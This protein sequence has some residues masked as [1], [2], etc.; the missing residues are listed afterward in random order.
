VRIAGW[1]YSYDKLPIEESIGHMARVGFDGIELATGEAFS[2]PIETLDDARV[3]RIGGLLD[4]HRLAPVAVSA[5]WRLAP[6]SEAEWEREWPKWRR[7][8]EVA[9]RLGAPFVA[10]GSGSAPEGWSREQ[11]WDALLRNGRRVADYAA[12][13]GVVVA[14][15]AHW[16][17]AVERPGDALELLAA[18]GSPSLRVNIDVCHPFALGYEL[19]SIAAILA[20]H[21]V[22]AHVC[23]VRGRHPGGPPPAGHQLVNPGEGEI[24]WPRWLGLLH[25]HG[26]Y[27]WIA[28][29]VSVMR[30][31]WPGYDPKA[32]MEEI[33]RVLTGAMAQAGV[34]R[35]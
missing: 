33:Y 24:D 16:G 25:Q 32:C 15:E 5:L 26:F 2:T 18:V 10:A 3:D 1:T 20:Q 28:T 4:Q 7:S 22:Y 9:A 19:E 23:D 35:L 17:A 31:A 14:I 6:P 11:L 13:R 34:P 27:G 8:I 29:Q 30:R 12:E 21:A